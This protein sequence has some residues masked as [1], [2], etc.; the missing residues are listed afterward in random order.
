MIFKSKVKEDL[1]QELRGFIFWY[2]SRVAS[3]SVDSATNSSILSHKVIGVCRH[4]KDHAVLVSLMDKYGNTLFKLEFYFISVDGIDYVTIK[5]SDIDG[6]GSFETYALTDY[7]GIENF[8]VQTIKFIPSA[9]YLKHYVNIF[10]NDIRSW[11]V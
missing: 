5:Y 7:V 9:T 6:L 1:Y 8:L 4:T 10:K 11:L 3:Y 2:Y